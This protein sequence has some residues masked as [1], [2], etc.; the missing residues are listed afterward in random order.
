MASAW[1][2]GNRYSWTGRNGSELALRQRVAQRVSGRQRGA[3]VGAMTSGAV[4][5]ELCQVAQDGRGDRSFPE[6]ALDGECLRWPAGQ[7][8]DRR[9]GAQVPARC[10]DEGGGRGETHRAASNDVEGAS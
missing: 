7:G 3:V 9:R 10:S 1:H 6:S 5:V 4:R 8:L 2:M